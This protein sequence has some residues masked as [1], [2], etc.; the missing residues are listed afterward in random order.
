MKLCAGEGR[1]QIELELH[2]CAEGA[3]VLLTGGEKTHIGAV[4]LAVP[5]L[6]L[7][8]KGESCDCYILPV[9]GHKDQEVAI[10]V[11]QALCCLLGE[12]VSVSAGIHIDSANADELVL[13]QNNCRR[14]LDAAIGFLRK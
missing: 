9:P 10:P 12:P 11:A 1:Y 14:V 3:N 2:R 6:S 13:L 5:R 7:A 8:G 4:V